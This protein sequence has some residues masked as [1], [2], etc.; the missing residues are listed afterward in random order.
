MVLPEDVRAGF[1]VPQKGDGQ[2]VPRVRHGACERAGSRWLLLAAR[3]HAGRTARAGAMVLED[4]RLRRRTAA[5]YLR[6]ARRR[7]ARACLIHATQL[8]W[9][10]GGIRS[11]ERR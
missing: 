9:S 1:G 11:E 7:M 2:L 4:H 8:D 5:R 6:K 3:K 10:L